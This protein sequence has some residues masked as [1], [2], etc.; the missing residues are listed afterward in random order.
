MTRKYL[1]SNK[2]NIYTQFFYAAR[3][4]NNGVSS[5]VEFLSDMK[6]INKISRCMLSRGTNADEEKSSKAILN[7]IIIISNN[8]KN[9]SLARI[10]FCNSKPETYPD[11]K[12]FLWFLHR[13]PDSIPEANLNDIELNQNLLKQLNHL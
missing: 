8:F 12:T 4:Y 10:L 13:L 1:W 2:L 11:L 9:E 7:Y 3:Y 6:L 5:W